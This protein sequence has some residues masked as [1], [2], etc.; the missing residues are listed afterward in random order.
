MA[1]YLYNGVEL[2][3]IPEVAGYQYLII[4]NFDTGIEFRAYQKTSHA[5]APYYRDQDKSLNFPG[6]HKYFSLTDGSWV[7]TKSNAYAGQWAEHEHYERY[8]TPIWTNFTFKDDTG[9]VLCE[10]SEP[11]PVLSID[12]TAMVQGW[13]VG[14]RL[15]AQRR[16]A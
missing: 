10:A 14:K 16:K 4:F 8:K 7:Q 1:N 2:P 15:A 5:G 12:H 6:T 13:I 3:E 9:E 11:V